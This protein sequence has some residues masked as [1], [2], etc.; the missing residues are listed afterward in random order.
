M[1]APPHLAAI[2]RTFEGVHPAGAGKWTARCPAHEDRSPSLSIAEGAEG[3]VLLK[4]HAGCSPESILSARGL[5]L[6][7]LFPSSSAP[8]RV[9]YEVCSR[10]GDVVAVHVRTEKPDGSKGFMWSRAN[11]APG[12]GGLRVVDLPLFGAE[13]LDGED[14]PVLVTEGEKAA[15]SLRTLGRL[16]LGTVTGAATAPSVR[17]LED[18]RGRDVILWPDHDEPD[19]SHMV[20]VF[21]ALQGIASSVRVFSWGSTPG[22]DAADFIARGGTAEELTRLLAT[23]SS[24]ASAGGTEQDLSP[25]PA[26][27]TQRRE[28]PEPLSALAYHGPLGELV[29]I[30]E[31]QTE[32]DPAAILLQLLAA[33]G[34]IVGSGPHAIGGGR[35]HANLFVA[36][37]GKTAKAR[38]GV[39]I[40]EA[41]RVFRLFT[42]GETWIAR[43]VLGGLSTG[44][45]I[46]S[47][48]RDAG[49]DDDGEGDKR[50]LFR[51]EELARILSAASRQGSTLSSVLRQAWDSAPLG[52]V[53]KAQRMHCAE[54]HVSV[55]AHC[56]R[57]ELAGILGGTDVH[58]GLAN[59]FLW[60]WA[61]RSKLLP[62]GGS[63]GDAE[64]EGI[65][66]EIAAAVEH[67]LGLGDTSV[68]WSDDARDLWAKGYEELSRERPGS[69]GAI[70]ARAEAHV[71]RLSLIFAL[72][73][74]SRSRHLRK[75]GPRES[76]LV[77]PRRAP[78]LR[79][80]D[81]F[82]S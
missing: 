42:V 57:H 37:I 76:P 69:L 40:F 75:R 3:R 36:V 4:C 73:D 56:T 82:S 25:A 35:H 28:S 11:G 20:R 29:R 12:L 1:S 24:V 65:A 41:L 74:Q 58:N 5:A 53:T 60:T 26:P 63:V 79:K 46:V 72:A 10:A 18:L 50:A 34:S 2:L 67:A 16:A 45:G 32:A 68:P 30:L 13:L 80:P 77:P 43:R 55:I 48:V 33:F 62:H 27:M 49:D 66:H 61:T 31:P 38:K 8:A 22:D 78:S 59:R 7:D 51:E 54:P 9:R 52:I 17:S 70:L 23:R 44:E 19:R 81:Q 15:L 64:L 39:S 21:E 71:I 47:A 14:G 6:S